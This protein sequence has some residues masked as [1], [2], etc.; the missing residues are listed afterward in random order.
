MGYLEQV[1]HFFHRIKNET[2]IEVTG[3]N[4]DAL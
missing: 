2:S 3:L 1:L 4:K